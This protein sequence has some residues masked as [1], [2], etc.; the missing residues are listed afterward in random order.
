MRQEALGRS[1][2]S[3]RSSIARWAGSSLTTSSRPPPAST[4]A[5]ICGSTRSIGLRESW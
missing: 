2:Q 1:V 5:A 3:A 4:R